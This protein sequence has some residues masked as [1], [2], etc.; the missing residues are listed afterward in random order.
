MCTL[1]DNNLVKLNSDEFEKTAF[2]NGIHMF[3][4]ND[5]TNF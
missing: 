2:D 1:L 5:H 3:R 4:V